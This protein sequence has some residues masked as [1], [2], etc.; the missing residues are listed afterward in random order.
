MSLRV[1]G[2]TLIPD[3]VTRLL[4]AQPT[5]S[6]K[7]GDV[8]YRAKDGRE[9]I[10]KIG[11]WMLSAE[12]RTPE[13]LDGQ[14]AD[15]LGKLT[16]DLDVWAQLA[17]RFEI[18]VFCGLFMRE[19]NEGMTLSAKTVLALGARGIELGLDIYDPTPPERRAR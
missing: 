15:T 7:N 3:E 12:H 17:R 11:L 19:S 9:T 2:E 5:K 1:G 8:Q 14:V 16:Q 4:G 18:D 6:R 13:D 10:A